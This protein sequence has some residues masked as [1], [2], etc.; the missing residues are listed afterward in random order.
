LP[1]ETTGHNIHHLRRASDV[2]VPWSSARSAF[3]SFV[4]VTLTLLL[5]LAAAIYLSCEY[6]V[7]GD[8]RRQSGA[9]PRCI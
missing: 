2:A 7:N 3:G 1:S 8:L 4:I 6:F 5:L 9:G